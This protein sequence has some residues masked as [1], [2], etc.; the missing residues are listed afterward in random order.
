MFIYREIYEN[1]TNAGLPLMKAAAQKKAYN[2][3]E[4]TKHGLMFTTFVFFFGFTKLGFINKLFLAGGKLSY[5]S[6]ILF[7]FSNIS[8]HS[9]RSQVQFLPR[10]S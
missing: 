5:Q 8:V 4:L 10:C 2:R 6:N 3:A 1:L 9:I 7:A